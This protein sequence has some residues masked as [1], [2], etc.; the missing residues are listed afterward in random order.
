M[1]AKDFE[2][3]PFGSVIGGGHRVH[4]P[5]VGH[6]EARPETIR[7]HGCGGL[8][9]QMGYVKVCEH[10]PGT[11]PHSIE[12]EP[13]PSPLVRPLLLSIVAGLLLAYA[14]PPTGWGVVAAVPAVALFLHA[15]G[16]GGWKAGLGFG[17]AFFG[18][19]FPWLGELGLEAVLPLVVL[20]ALFTTAYSVLVWRAD[21]SK[22]W[23]WWGIAVSGW[24][25]M[26]LLR[27]RIP[28]GG[29]PWGML[30]FT[31]AGYP[32]GR[33]AAQWIGTSGW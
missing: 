17:L 28:L 15:A 3:R 9:G 26:E 27:E 21:S 31:L 25:V 12:V 1:P 10:G 32:A 5:F 13:I 11:L 33:H 22:P 20:Q 24:G 16:L 7:D 6:L 30:G 2:Q 19:L 23:I 14:L 4:I 8:C 18:A 29:F